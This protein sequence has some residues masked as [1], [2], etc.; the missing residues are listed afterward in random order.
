MERTGREVAHT[1]RTELQEQRLVW[2]KIQRQG[3]L[4]V[5]R[6]E[7]NLPA[8]AAI[9]RANEEAVVRALALMVPQRRRRRAVRTANQLRRKVLDR[10]FG[11]AL[12]DASALG[13]HV[14]GH[15]VVFEGIM[16]VF[17]LCQGGIGAVL[18]DL[19]FGG[20][21]LSGGQVFLGLLLKQDGLLENVIRRAPQ[22]AVEKADGETEKKAGEAAQPSARPAVSSVS[23]FSS[24]GAQAQA[25]AREEKKENN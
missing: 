15:Q 3:S 24:A 23:P 14:E 2:R 8:V 4:S 12:H 16:L 5:L 19:L 11:A 1:G 18:T 10:I 21:S 6:R 25:V 13:R 7:G 22:S 9:V 17:P 20:G